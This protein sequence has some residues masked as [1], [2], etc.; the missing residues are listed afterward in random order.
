MTAWPLTMS[1]R[2]FNENPKIIE[3]TGLADKKKKLILSKNWLLV[4]LGETMFEIKILKPCV[5]FKFIMRK[6][7]LLYYLRD[8]RPKTRISRRHLSILLL[9]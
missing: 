9:V 1:F 4:L 2:F 5:L 3:E 8:A 6:W 7:F